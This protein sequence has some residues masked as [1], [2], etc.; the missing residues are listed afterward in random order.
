LIPFYFVAATRSS[1]LRTAFLLFL[2]FPVRGFVPNGHIR[3]HMAAGISYSTVTDFAR[4]LG[5]S[6][7]RFLIFAT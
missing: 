1:H 7:S 4:F 3:R 6:I 5:L 2:Y